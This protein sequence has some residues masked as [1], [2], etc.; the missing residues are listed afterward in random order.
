MERSSLPDVLSR[1]VESAAAIAARLR[2]EADPVVAIHMESALVTMRIAASLLPIDLQA[3]PCSSTAAPMEQVD[4]PVW[5]RVIKPERMAGLPAVPAPQR[6]PDAGVSV[7]ASDAARRLASEAAGASLL[8][9]ALGRWSWVHEATRTTWSCSPSAA[10][11]LVSALG[12]CRP[13]P[14]GPEMTGRI[15]AD[16][17]DVM[18]AVGWTP[19]PRQIRG[20]TLH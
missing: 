4:G 16:A 3:G 8:A 7:I 5:K 2:A 1:L 18:A 6:G 14:L 17:L 15:D 20:S 11:A 12:R 10:R 13:V 9:D 19:H